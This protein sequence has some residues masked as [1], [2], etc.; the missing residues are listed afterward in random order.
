MALRGVLT[1]LLV[2]VA[3]LG[4]CRNE[5]ST[6]RPVTSVAHPGAQAAARGPQ[7]HAGV[8]PDCVKAAR[9]LLALPGMDDYELVIPSGPVPDCDGSA[10]G[11]ATFGLTMKGVRG[12]GLL[13][14]SHESHRA[15]MFEAPEQAK[16]T[17]SSVLPW[18]ELHDRALSWCRGLFP[19][20]PSGQKLELRSVRLG[21]RGKLTCE[22]SASARVGGLRFDLAQ[23][24]AV[25]LD[26]ASGRIVGGVVF[27]ATRDRVEAV[28]DSLPPKRVVEGALARAADTLGVDEGEVIAL[29][30]SPLLDMLPTWQPG[31]PG[32]PT[33]R[34]YGLFCSRIGPAPAAEGVTQVK[35]VFGVG[36]PQVT[37]SVD[38]RQRAAA[39]GRG[40][41]PIGP[42]ASA[43]D[44]ARYIAETL[45]PSLGGRR[46]LSQ[47]AAKH[48]ARN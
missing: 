30:V 9:D 15:M 3:V 19:D 29:N 26:V 17:A 41:P 44:T 39:D 42:A 2:L 18:E 28:A 4:G 47:Y 14:V 23:I 27:P 45:D 46:L 38:R 5:G 43:A 10:P 7:P 24:A 31:H 35:I 32:P 11:T 21:N 1:A 6:S 13:L 8:C 40:R 16:K 34:W 22:F 36:S 33:G 37:R 20:L 12:Q 25:E 48:C